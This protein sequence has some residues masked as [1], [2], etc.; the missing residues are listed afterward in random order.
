MIENTRGLFLVVLLAS[1]PAEGVQLPPEILVDQLLLRGERLIQEQETE[2]A[3]EIIQEILAL[4]EKHGFELPPEFHF[5]RA[6]AMFAAGTLAPARESVTSYLTA[7]GRDGEFYEDALALLEDVD[8]ILERRDAP[9]CA[10]Q[11]EGTECW[12]ELT[13]HA[14]C[15]V[16]NEHLQSE[17]TA[18]WTGACSSGFATSAGTLTWEWPPDNRQEHDGTMRLGRRHG[19]WILRFQDGYIEE[20]S[21][22]DGKRDGHWVFTF[23]DSGI[24]EGPFVDGEKNGP[25]VLRYA[26][27][28]IEEGPVVAGQKNGH[29][30]LR[31]ADGAIHEGPLVDG[32]RNGHW[33]ETWPDGQI[34]EGPFVDGKEHGHWVIRYSDGDVAEGPYVEGRKH[35]QWVIT[36]PDG[37]VEKGAYIADKKQGRWV[38]KEPAP[39]ARICEIR[40]VNGDAVDEWDCHNRDGEI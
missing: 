15:H 12:M 21:F 6:Q 13:N 19:P 14:G 33:A 4:Q 5:R 16:W 3:L 36:K 7:T 8:R 27:G 18:E 25:W 35:G 40:Y 9:D 37:V 1:V 23:P 26:D 30:V 24:Q 29:W 2:A 10:G 32:Q 39:N 31:Y 20:G 17:P 34:E 11:P 28:S 22:L 38:W